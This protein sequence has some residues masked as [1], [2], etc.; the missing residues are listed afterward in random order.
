MP[1]TRRQCLCTAPLLLLRASPS[2]ALRAEPAQWSEAFLESIGVCTHW[3]YNDTPYGYAYDQVKRLLIDSGIRHIRDGFSERIT[4]L[5]QHGITTCLCVGPEASQKPDAMKVADIVQ[6]IK[7]INAQ[8]PSIDAV[9]GPNE[10]DLFWPRFHISYKGEGADRGTASIVKGVTAFMADLYFAVK[11]EPATAKL[12]V[13][14]PSLGVTYDPGA[15]HPNPFPKASLTNYVDWGNFHPYCGGNPFSFPFPYDTLEKYY[16]QG[17]FPSSKLDEFPYAFRTYAPPFAPKPMAATETG[18]STD[19]AGPSEVVHAKYMPRLFC[20]N[21]RL[22]IRRSYSYEFIDEFNDPDGT[23]REAHFGLVRRDLTPKPAYYAVKNLITLLRD[24]RPHAGFKPSTLPLTIHVSS[25]KDY[26]EPISGQVTNYDRTQYVHHLLL[27]KS[28][29][30]FWILLWHEIADEDASVTPPRPIQPPAMPTEVF[31][32]SNFHKAV[33]YRPNNGIH[34]VE[35]D[36][37]KGHL[38]LAVPDELL[39]VQLFHH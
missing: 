38:S 28:D 25:V 26:R 14:G 1:I 15:G 31:L 29:G 24:K 36:I 37:I 23:N 35:S 22:G 32:P 30:Q 2:S 8:Q 12:T 33:I 39:V 17:D 27:Q 34:G 7:A 6:R 5:G 13:I 9:E 11:S 19:R 21:F 3:T 18:Y 10:P 16:W 4:D 20:E